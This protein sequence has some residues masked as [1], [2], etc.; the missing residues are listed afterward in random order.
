MRMFVEAGGL[1]EVGGGVVVACDHLG[2]LFRGS[3]ST[4]VAGGESCDAEGARARL[5]SWI[6]RS[7]MEND[8]FLVL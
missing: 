3:S 5:G 8:F 6:P 1:I 4:T 7:A 2:F